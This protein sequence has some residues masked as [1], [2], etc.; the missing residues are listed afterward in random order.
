VADAVFTLTIAAKP[1]QP[2]PCNNNLHFLRS[3]KQVMKTT[4]NKLTFVLP[5]LIFLWGHLATAQTRLS[6]SV[7]DANGKPL[8]AAS[9]LLLSSADSTLVKGQLS[10]ADGT[11]TFTETAAGE[12][13]LGVSMLGFTYALS[14][15]FSIDPAMPSKDLGVTTLQENTE[16]LGEVSVVAKK[17]LFE[18]RID[19]MV[20][21]VANSAT[22]AGG[23]A[24]EVLQR[25]PGVMVNRQSNALSM[26]GKSGIVIMING[27]INRMPSDALIQMLGGMNADN[28]ERI[29]LIH[30][31]P[32]NFDAEGNAGIINIILKKTADAGL[33][34][35]YSLNAGYGKREKYGAGLNFNYRKKKVN[36]FGNYDYRYN[37]NP[38]V[39]TNYR[40]IQEGDNFLETESY[41]DRNPNLHIQ[42]AQLGADFQVSPKTVVGV[43][44]TFF[45]RY[46]DMYAVNDVKYST[47]GAENSSLKMITTEVNHWNSWTGNVNLSHQFAKD[48]TLNVD[49][50][51]V[52]YHIDNPSTYDVQYTGPEQD[53][54]L[55]LFKDNPIKIGVVK[56]DYNQNIGTKVQFEAGVKGASSNF[57]NDVRVEELDLENWIADPDLTSRFKLTEDI[58]AAYSSFSLK[59][60]DK[61]DVK[62]GLRYEYTRTNLGSLEQPDVVDRR[63]G[64]WFPSA[65]VSR[66]ISENQSANL[67][68]SRRIMRPGFTQLAPYL[69]FYDPTTLEGGNPA[70]QP[71]FTNSIKFDYRLKSWQLSVEYSKEDQSIR[72]IPVI[73]YVKNTQFNRPENVGNSQG[74]FA[75]LFFQLHPAKWWDMQNNLMGLINTSKVNYEGAD[76]DINSHFVGINSTQ[77]FTLPK[78][79][80]VEV[81][82]NYFSPGYW[83]VYKWKANGILSIGVQKKLSEKWGTLSFNVNDVFLSGNWFSEANQPE[84]NLHVRTS[85]QQTERTFMLTW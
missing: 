11:Y 22:N 65:Y 50:D 61:T 38:Q 41:S 5:A 47:N 55:R 23:T 7:A 25:S 33:N 63:Y 9:V 2:T 15:A 74:V 31:P 42:N 24:L 39:F 62:L 45:D 18:Q 44:G 75:S 46:W 36:L 40:G 26:A 59:V 70:L 4:T 48:K 84:V 3:F 49:A 34:G 64:S 77:S 72:D 71:A 57:D 14:P 76:L 73:D 52:Y 37:K 20:I 8:P 51:Y 21:N 54:K 32:A 10:S 68:Y 78:S 27:K 79:F 13:R 67:S 85:Y 16:M 30:T 58:A 81:S 80:V 17:P 19:R 53:R 6:G 28:I 35:G 69:I 29:E 56:A 12:Y 83:G 82:A 1:I 43:L 66:K 60:N